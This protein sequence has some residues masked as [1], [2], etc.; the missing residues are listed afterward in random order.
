MVL[1]TG[2]GH[3]RV[4]G[5][6]EFSAADGKRYITSRGDINNAEQM[7]RFKAKVVGEAQDQF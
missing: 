2:V 7:F 3:S 6:C 4:A 1:K 5:F